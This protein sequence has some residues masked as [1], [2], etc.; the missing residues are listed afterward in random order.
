MKPE[1]TVKSLLRTKI[2][3]ID[4]IN[5]SNVERVFSLP[6]LKRLGVKFKGNDNIYIYPDGGTLFEEAQSANSIGS[7]AAKTLRKLPCEVF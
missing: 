4:N 3:E 2:V 6:S 5:S 1:I 7:W